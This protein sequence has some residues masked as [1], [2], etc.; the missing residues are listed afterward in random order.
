MALA[1]LI[2]SEK[3]TG[4]PLSKHKVLF[5]GAG[6]AGAGIADLIAAQIVQETKVSLE[7]ARERI[8]MM[9]SRSN[10]YI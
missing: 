1:G 6:E 2:A 10:I 9:D 4:I 5:Y 7:E 3:L 8:Y